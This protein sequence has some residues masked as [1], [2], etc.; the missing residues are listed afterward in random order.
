MK[1]FEKDQADEAIAYAAAGGQAFHVYPRLGMDAPACF[2]RS[3][4]WAHLYDQDRFR[5]CET[6]RR[7]GVNVIVVHRE[8]EV[9]QHVDLCGK[10]LARADA[11]CK[12]ALNA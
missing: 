1:R 9:T 11:K 3:P 10:P 5:L 8:G 2:Q 4:L 6:A 12:D 7:L